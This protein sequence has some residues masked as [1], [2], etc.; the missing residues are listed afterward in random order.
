MKLFVASFVLAILGSGSAA[1]SAALGLSARDVVC[2]LVQRMAACSC[3]PYA[4]DIVATYN[5]IPT[6]VDYS[7]GDCI[8]FNIDGSEVASADFNAFSKCY[9]FSYVHI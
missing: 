9:V 4:Q 6:P 2:I 5:G 3:F 1:P 7:F 8:P